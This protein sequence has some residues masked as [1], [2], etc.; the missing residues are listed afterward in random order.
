MKEPLLAI[1]LEQKAAKLLEILQRRCFSGQENIK[2]LASVLVQFYD[3]G[4]N[5]SILNRKLI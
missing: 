3:D 2:Y 5:E 1:E 4:Y